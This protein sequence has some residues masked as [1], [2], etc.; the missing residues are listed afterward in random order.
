MKRRSNLMILVDLYHSLRKLNTV[1]VI[2]NYTTRSGT[3]DF[4]L[5]F[6]IVTIVLSRTVFEISAISVENR[7]FF[8]PPCIYS[9]DEGVSP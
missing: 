5:T 8:L 1:K 9:P 6:H 7:Q 3:H 4:L 2:E